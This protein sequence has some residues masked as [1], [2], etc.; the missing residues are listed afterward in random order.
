MKYAFLLSG[1]IEIV[2]GIICYV[3]PDFIAPIDGSVIFRLYAINA[4]V[5]GLLNIFL[6]VHYEENKF[7]K[8]CFLA[9]MFFHA[10]ISVIVYSAAPTS[11][12]FQLP[13]TLA[14][15]ALF[16]IFFLSYMKDLKPDTP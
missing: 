7:F 6:Y 14:H 1:I 8:N 11:I 10:A 9:M 12:T 4:L 13:A 3:K 2:G 15:L 5:L 16:V